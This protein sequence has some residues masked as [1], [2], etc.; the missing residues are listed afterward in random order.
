MTATIGQTRYYSDREIGLPGSTTSLNGESDY[1]AK[2]RFLLLDN[3]NFDFGHQ[4]GSWCER[5]HAIR[6]AAAVSSSQ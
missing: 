3:V 5:Y 1:I 4:W 2:L 6:S